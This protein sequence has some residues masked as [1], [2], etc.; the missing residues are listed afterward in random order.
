MSQKNVFSHNFLCCFYRA[1]TNIDSFSNDRET[2]A[3]SIII[4]R[5]KAPLYSGESPRRYSRFRTVIPRQLKTIKKIARPVL[6]RISQRHIS[7]LHVMQ[8][9]RTLNQM[10]TWFQTVSRKSC[11]G[12][13]FENLLVRKG[14]S[15]LGGF[16]PE[17]KTWWH[18]NVF[19]RESMN[20]VLFPNYGQKIDSVTYC[21]GTTVKTWE[22]GREVG[23]LT[24][25]TNYH[26]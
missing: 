1:G 24:A 2:K 21:T 10:T 13:R 23:N 11:Q 4:N 3:P 25:P 18:R 5:V 8:R 20:A 17:L 14:K 9:F 6:K 16:K 7:F 15:Q 19:S 12:R 26:P 22:T